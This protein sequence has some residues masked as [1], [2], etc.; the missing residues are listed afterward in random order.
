MNFFSCII[1]LVELLL[2]GFFLIILNVLVNL[3]SIKVF[4]WA[5]LL[6]LAQFIDRIVG[7]IYMTGLRL[8]SLQNDVLLWWLWFL[9][10][11]SLDF[12]ILN[13]FVWR[14]VKRIGNALLMVINLDGFSCFRPSWVLSDIQT[15]WWSLLVPLSCTH[16]W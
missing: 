4:S 13:L 12:M 6:N 5:L 11:T 14:L 2:L 9:I 7:F 3:R 15:L 16:Q 1:F 10:L 8:F